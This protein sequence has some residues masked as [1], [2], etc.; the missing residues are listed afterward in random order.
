[1]PLVFTR[2][3]QSSQIKSMLQKNNLSLK[4]LS[5][6]FGV[7]FIKNRTFCCTNYVESDF[8]IKCYFW[9]GGEN[10]MPTRVY[11]GLWRWTLILNRPSRGP[12]YV[13]FQV[14]LNRPS[15]WPWY[16]KVL[17]L[18]NRPSHGPWY[19][20]VLVLPYRRSHRPWYV[21]VLVWGNLVSVNVLIFKIHAMQSLNT[22]GTTDQ[23]DVICSIQK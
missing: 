21:N 18:L 11:M 7:S 15:H 10:Q 2:E 23:R 5:T 12:L 22:G 14:L 6:D 1:M 8:H 16:V 17:V 3:K 19:V 9:S 13:K 20:K 4:L